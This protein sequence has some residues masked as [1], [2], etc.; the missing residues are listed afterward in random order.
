M[1]SFLLFERI[2]ELFIV[3]FFGWLVVKLGI[4]KSLQR[5]YEKGYVNW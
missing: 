4:L 2:A 1:L 3:I 5:L